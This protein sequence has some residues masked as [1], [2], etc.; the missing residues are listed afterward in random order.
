MCSFTLQQKCT[1]E[2]HDNTNKSLFLGHAVSQYEV[3]RNI[4]EEGT[5]E[6]YKVAL[7]LAGYE[8]VIL[9]DIE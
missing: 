1:L 5:I 3:R 2:F 6:R 9:W 7:R 4:Y 8:K